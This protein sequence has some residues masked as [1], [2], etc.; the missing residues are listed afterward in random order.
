MTGNYRTEREIHN[1][2]LRVLEGPVRGHW[3]AQGDTFCV[4]GKGFEA[5]GRL[6]FRLRK[7]G[8][9][10]DEYVAVN[11]DTGFVWQMFIYRR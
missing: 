10:A 9:G 6:C 7:G 4:E 11:V 5:P 2:R 3:T 1:G 8:F